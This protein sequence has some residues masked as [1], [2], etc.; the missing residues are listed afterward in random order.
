MLKLLIIVYFELILHEYKDNLML[1][2]FYLV[3]KSIKL[4]PTFR[5]FWGKSALKQNLLAFCGSLAIKQEK[6][7]LNDRILKLTLTL[8]H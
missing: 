7:G 2:L 1:N 6:I 4:F 5:G 8:F 3:I